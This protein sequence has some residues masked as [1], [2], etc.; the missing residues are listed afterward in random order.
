MFCVLT[1]YS[2]FGIKTGKRLSCVY[3]NAIQR[4]RNEVFFLLLSFVLFVLDGPVVAQQALLSDA[5]KIL[6]EKD[7]PLFF[8]MHA[9]KG[10]SS[11]LQKNKVLQE[12]GRHEYERIRQSVNSCL[13]VSCYADAGKW[14]AE[15]I[16]QDGD[17]LVSLLMKEKKLRDL[18]TSLRKNHSYALYEH[19]ADSSYLRQ[20]WINAATGVNTIVDVYVDGKP[21]RY[22]KIDSIS[23]RPQDSVFE[24]Q[25]AVVLKNLFYDK[26]AAFYQ[27]PVSIAIKALTLNGRNEA[28]RYEPLQQGLNRLP[29]LKIRQT[30]FSAYPYSIIL[31]PGLG[32]E[33]PGVSLDPGGARRC[34]AAVKRYRNGLAP[35]IVV[36]GG[37]VHPFKTPFNEAEQMKKYMVGQLGVPADAVIIEPHARHTTTNIRNT[38]RL[39]YR[40][41]MP[42][43]KP[44]LIVTDS[45]QNS[46]IAQRMAQTAMR[47]LG[48]LPYQQL[49]KLS[50]EETTFLPVSTCLHTDPSD[51]LDP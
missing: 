12:N 36:S 8:V 45:S 2:C 42:A 24:S 15:E 40:L 35:F 32:P 4:G 26:H 50:D 25:V 39:I 13:E 23:F 30:N 19:D 28:A 38:C 33:Q 49:K 22:P 18:V 17:E 37:N 14:T 46:Y 51:P 1:A 47:D 48:Y 5:E 44:L 34:E 29:F 3:M 16:K 10:I 20:A 27:L 41:H 6:I 11:V 9:D 43:D 21:P 7:F 31:V